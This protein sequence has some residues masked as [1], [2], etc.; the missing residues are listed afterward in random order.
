MSE[1]SIPISAMTLGEDEEALV[2]RVLRSGHLVQG[3]MVDR[4]EQAFAELCG[5]EYAVAVSS[6]TSALALA[7]ESL[8]LEPGAEVLTSP[9]TFV[10]TLNAI[11]EAGATARFVDIDA[12]DFTMQTDQL[13]DQ[14]TDRTLVILPVHLYGQPAAMET[15]APIADARGIAIIEDAA[16]AHGATVHGRSVGSFGIGCFSLYATKN[17]TTGEGG[18]VTTNDAKVAD[19]LRLLRNQ[20][21]RR[22]YEYE[23][24][25]HNCRLTDLHAAIG[26]A[27]LARLE[28]FTASRRRNAAQLDAG[29]AGLP[30]LVLPAGTPERTHVF[31]QYTVRV[32][33][34]A[35]CD[36]DTLAEELRRRGIGTGL[37]YP[38]AVYDYQCYRDHPR[39]R[40]ERMPEAERAAREVLSLPVHPALSDGDLDRI[41]TSVRTVLDS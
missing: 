3:P 5:V 36:R 25:G 13:E 1:L 35:R 31:H 2:L 9:F 27:Q 16:Q 4:L 28:T 41:V 29:L 37:Y 20:G 19:R 30:G 7:V 38:R 32:T 40:V 22:R 18:V 11:L 33:A 8:G 39:V 14:I 23:L 10:A 17:V 6:G 21:M 15:I 12:N 24:P 26:V 34:E